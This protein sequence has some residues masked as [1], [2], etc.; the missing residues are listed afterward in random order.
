MGSW[1]TTPI[2]TCPCFEYAPFADY[3]QISVKYPSASHTVAGHA[4]QV[5]AEWANAQQIVEGDLEPLQSSGEERRGRLSLAKDDG[6][7]YGRA[8]MVEPDT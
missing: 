2:T 6:G 3:Q 4:S 7:I 1:F 8:G 5:A